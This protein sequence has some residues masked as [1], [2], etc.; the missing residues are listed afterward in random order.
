MPKWRN[1]SRLLKITA[2][3]FDNFIRQGLAIFRDHGQ[4]GFHRLPLNVGPGSLQNFDRG[5]G[6]FRANTITGN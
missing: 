6:N 5:S 4:A 2:I 3:G 1:I